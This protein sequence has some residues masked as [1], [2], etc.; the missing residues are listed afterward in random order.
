MIDLAEKLATEP[1]PVHAPAHAPSGKTPKAARV[2]KDEEAERESYTR[3]L[4]SY[5]DAR[6]S[7]EKTKETLQDRIVSFLRAELSARGRSGDKRERSGTEGGQAEPPTELGGSRERERG[8]DELKVIEE[9]KRAGIILESHQARFNEACDRIEKKKDEA[10]TALTANVRERYEAANNECTLLY[11]PK[12]PSTA[13]GSGES[14]FTFH[15]Q[16]TARAR[17]LD[18]HLSGLLDTNKRALANEWLNDDFRTRIGELLGKTA[19]LIKACEKELAEETAK[20]GEE[21]QGLIEDINQIFVRLNRVCRAEIEDIETK[22]GSGSGSIQDVDAQVKY[23]V[24]WLPKLSDALDEIGQLIT[25][26]QRIGNTLIEAKK[27]LDTAYT[28]R[29]LVGG[30]VSALLAGFE[31]MR[32]LDTEMDALIVQLSDFS[33]KADDSTDAEWTKITTQYDAI[34][35]S[36]LGTKG[37]YK[38]RLE[39]KLSTLY[40]AFRE[41]YALVDKEEDPASASGSDYAPLSESG[42]DDDSSVGDTSDE[43]KASQAAAI[44]KATELVGVID[45]ELLQYS[46]TVDHIQTDANKAL[47]EAHTRAQLELNRKLVLYL[48]T[49]ERY[50][51]STAADHLK[52]IAESK[53]LITRAFSTKVLRPPNIA[54]LVQKLDELG[55]RIQAAQKTHKVFTAGAVRGVFELTKKSARYIGGALDRN[56]NEFDDFR[57]SK[58]AEKVKK[59]SEAA[60]IFALREE[61]E[62]TDVLEYN[63]VSSFF[64]HTRYPLIPNQSAPG[65]DFDFQN[66]DLVT[67]YGKDMTSRDFIDFGFARALL[68]DDARVEGDERLLAV[69]S[70]RDTGYPFGS[71]L[72]ASVVALGGQSATSDPNYNKRI[73]LNLIHQQGLSCANHAM[74]N[75]CKFS[76]VIV[77]A[78]EHIGAKLSLLSIKETDNI[79]RKACDDVETLY[80][81][82]VS[83][84]PVAQSNDEATSR[85]TAKGDITCKASDTS[86]APIGVFPLAIEKYGA[87]F[88]GDG[89]FL[90][91]HGYKPTLSPADKIQPGV[92]SAWAPN[93]ANEAEWSTL[94]EQI[95][96]PIAG[97]VVFNPANTG[98]YVSVVPVRDKIINASLDAKP[99]YVILDSMTNHYT[100]N[101]DGT[102]AN[103]AKYVGDT[104]MVL[105]CK[106]IEDAPSIYKALVDH[107]SPNAKRDDMSLRM[108]VV[109]LDASMHAPLYESVAKKGYGGARVAALGRFSFLFN[110]ALI[111]DE[112]VKEANWCAG[113]KVL[114][115]PVGGAI[116]DL[117]QSFY[118]RKSTHLI[119]KYKLLLSQNLADADSLVVVMYNN[120]GLTAMNTTDQVLFS[121]IRSGRTRKDIESMATIFNRTMSV[122][123]FG[124]RTVGR[125]ARI[126]RVSNSF[127]ISALARTMKLKPTRSTSFGEYVHRAAK[128]SSHVAPRAALARYMV[129][130]S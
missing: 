120:E 84:L 107:L 123:S 119:K 91:V 39:A 15:T 32:A 111:L 42:S 34:K 7:F 13:S 28:E 104:S 99:R 22:I 5:L 71:Y 61:P 94:L 70:N 95:A 129:T 80:A 68:L 118:A 37:V 106:V 75:M 101:A 109:T 50:V 16:K 102:H 26:A 100:R 128:H 23:L 1:V 103:A 121:R 65:R 87:P 43:Q 18:A 127:G 72:Y 19:L 92:R 63:D 62:N 20:L 115:K 81:E 47:K 27:L 3:D 49:V 55:A 73:Q 89:A 88:R 117:A 110:E 124:R 83:S 113:D 29:D 76:C 116:Y 53:T 36:W 93:V 78:K 45:R 126:D 85:Q 40:G 69:C 66:I 17:G 74:Y 38:K 48:S 56:Y 82:Y 52:L 46:Q 59:E 10:A 6:E 21:E 96:D 24:D 33:P 130:R 35:L 41:K 112:Y 86:F 25:D 2:Y 77:E 30:L 4:M 14:A 90:T 125:V 67:E 8:A 105:T 9:A 60:P 122:V 98:H 57:R 12:N 108:I 51:V 31:E 58:E 114:V 11:D 79:I 64:I 54:E 44:K 97:I